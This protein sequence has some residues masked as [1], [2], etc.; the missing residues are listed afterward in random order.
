MDE[1]SNGPG[2]TKHIQRHNNRKSRRL[3]EPQAPCG[4]SCPMLQASLPVFVFPAW[5]RAIHRS[6]ATA[7]CHCPPAPQALTAELKATV[8]APTPRAKRRSQRAKGQ[9]P[10]RNPKAYVAGCFFF[11]DVCCV[12]YG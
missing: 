5:A 9:S 11:G 4:A 2:T 7:L 1:A 6:S 3:L 12:V 10:G 8:P